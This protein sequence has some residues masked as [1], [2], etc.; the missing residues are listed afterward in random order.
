MFRPLNW[1]TETDPGWSRTD[2]PLLGSFALQT[3]VL[4]LHSMDLLYDPPVVIFCEALYKFRPT[5]THIITSSTKLKTQTKAQLLHY[6]LLYFAYKTLNQTEPTSFKRK[7]INE[8]YKQAL[9]NWSVLQRNNFQQYSKSQSN[10]F[11]TFFN[12][13]KIKWILIC[14]N[15][16]PCC[17]VD[18]DPYAK[19]NN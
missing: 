15:K 10:F 8:N 5:N 6:E 9:A 19:L 1:I 16:K 18:L 3:K 11:S 17:Q 13:Y 14:N 7:N 12:A 2:A 4:V